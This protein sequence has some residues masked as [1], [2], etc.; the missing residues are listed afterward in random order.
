MK[1]QRKDHLCGEGEKRN[2]GSEGLE[3]DYLNFNIP[4]R[5]IPPTE[6]YIPKFPSPSSSPNKSYVEK[7]P[8]VTHLERNTSRA[9]AHTSHPQIPV[10]R[11]LLL[12]NK[13]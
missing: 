4:A 1:W 2:A 11:L 3:D 6:G 9:G 10:L 7:Y 13:S 8:V 12:R 5:E